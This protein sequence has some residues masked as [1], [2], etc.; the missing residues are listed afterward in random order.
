MRLIATFIAVVLLAVVLLTATALVLIRRALLV[1]AVDQ[2]VTALQDDLQTA[3]QHVASSSEPPADGAFRVLPDRAL[4]RLVDFMAPREG[5]ELVVVQHGGGSNYSTSIRVSAEEVPDDLVTRVRD[6]LIAYAVQERAGRRELVV[7]GRVSRDALELYRF[8]DLTA[9]E[10]ALGVT[11]RNI[12]FAG[13][14]PLL[15]AV[16]MGVVA[17]RAVLRPV[18]RA[19]D[20]AR[21]VTEGD[22]A[23]RIEVAGMD[24]LAELAEDFNEMAASLKDSLDGLQTVVAG[25]R[26]FVADVAHEL[27]TPL[28]ALTAAVAV[29][30]ED[31]DDHGDLEQA[32]HLVA[33]EVH[34]LRRLV[35]DLLEI[36]RFDA[37]VAELQAHDVGLR[38][39][40]EGALDRRGARRQVRNEV[41][42]DL[43]VNVDPR[44]MDTVV[45]NLV[46][47]AQ[48]HALPP[49]HVRAWA[50]G[51]DA[52]IA[53]SD[54]GPGIPEAVRPR[55][56]DRFATA[57]AARSRTGGSGLGLAIA[58][59]NIHLH[60]GDLRVTATG[61]NGTTMEVVIP[62]AIVSTAD[63]PHQ[64][65]PH[66]HSP[67]APGDT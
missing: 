35:E 21:R 38:A 4:A 8:V 50:N 20:V 42:E 40:V 30:D 32:R 29:L 9:V 53:V 64:D 6:G 63:S 37:G 47:N 60:G 54:A 52:H 18:R 66:K 24:E 45:G 61:P 39:L 57:D 51:V 26:R 33:T 58:Q 27:R 11:I 59:E 41:P 65:R 67:A 62:A 7:G 19:R 15:V 23:A 17:A 22:L 56:F 1:G 49:I 5:T 28:T 48:V 43:R 44:R 46:T 3:S 36:S 31:H 10:N 25:Q 14:A 2:A 12:L 16:A 55:L 13:T 34:A